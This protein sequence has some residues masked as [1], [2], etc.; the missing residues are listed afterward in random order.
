M[1]RIVAL[2]IAVIG[3][4]DFAGVAGGIV[5][6]TPG[7]SA[8]S[9][10]YALLHSMV[11][12]AFAATKPPTIERVTVTGGAA[13]FEGRAEAGVVVRLLAANRM[14]AE[15]RA[16]RDG[17]WMIRLE[18]GLSS[19]EHRLHVVALL[20]NASEI[21]GDE[22]R[23]AVPLGLGATAVVAF[24]SV[25]SQPTEATGNVAKMPEV[26]AR[27]ERLAEDAGQAFAE[28]MKEWNPGAPKSSADSDMRP[29][30]GAGAD[31]PTPRPA[32]IGTDTGAPSP[33]TPDNEKPGGAI[34]RSIDQIVDWLRRSARTY[35]ERIAKELSVPVPGAPTAPSVETAAKA[36]PP[37]APSVADPQK[38]PQDRDTERAREDAKR[39]AEERRRAEDD[40]AQRRNAE[41]ARRAEDQKRR[42]AAAAQEAERE[43]EQ[44][45]K[46]AEEL[47]RRKEEIDRQI[48]ENL[49]R[50]KE[51]RA[52]ADRRN[53]SGNTGELAPR[54]PQPPIMLE[55]FW[56][57]GEK[58]NDDAR[59][60]RIEE[61]E[62][63]PNEEGSAEPP[64][65]QW[66]DSQGRARLISD[67]TDSSSSLT[68]SSAT[69]CRTGRMIYRHGKRWYIV[70]A[71]DTLWSIA[72]RSY[73]S[74]RR[75]T[76]I[77]NANRDRLADPDIVK[78][79]Q[80][81]RLPR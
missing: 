64:I 62:E 9:G 51:A 43:A 25:P 49:E 32:Q 18:E 27:A 52:E 57:P 39:V 26:R 3:A 8:R 55:R 61:N 5:T 56:L 14:I 53:G 76:R 19:G 11:P 36:A 63:T 59:A 15:T 10:F 72:R 33:P 40:A 58:P 22:V 7:E 24:E 60:A 81:L 6:A 2:A 80:R 23:I 35:D 16:T 68:G 74:G 70:G 42:A 67:G 47:R 77:Y 79:C 69:R 65:V 17:R 38:K 28:V 46:A 29:Q 71:S 73:G 75:W 41:D 78:P 34:G 13:E 66:I 21:V 31:K 1:Q 48:A 37:S 20:S 44:E 50:L 54:A 45:R 12:S 4:A 30:Q